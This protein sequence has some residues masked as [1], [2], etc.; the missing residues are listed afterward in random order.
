MTTL[1]SLFDRTRRLYKDS[2]AIVDDEA[3]FTWNEF[4][5][6]LSRAANLLAKMGLEKGD[7]YAILSTNSFRHAEL[8][9]G[10]YWS[11]CI[12]VP[13]N[14]RLAPKEIAA[15]LED[16]GAKFLFIE[17]SF[18]EVLETEEL[19]S[20]KSRHLLLPTPGGPKN[21]E[22]DDLLE[23]CSP[24]KPQIAEDEDLAILIY[25]G[26]TTGRSKGVRLTHRNIIT[27]GMQVALAFQLKS[28]DI[29]LH[30]A[31]MFHSAD[32]LGTGFLMLGTA[33]AYISN[34]TPKSILEMLEKTKTTSIMLPPTLVIGILQEPD[35]ANYDLSNLR[36]LFYG[37]A[38]MDAEWI[39]KTL[40]A[41]PNTEIIQLYGTTEASPILTSLGDLEHR[42]AVE[43]EREELLKSAGRTVLGLDLIIV[44]DDGNEVPRGEHGEVALRGGNLTKGYLNL[45]EVTKKTIRG[46]Y[47]HTGDVGWMDEQGYLFLLDRKNDMII[48]G[49]ENV[50][51][52]EVEAALYKHPN[53]HETAVVGIPDEKYG[54]AVFAAIV[55]KPGTSI[56]EQ[57]IIDHCRQYIGGFKIPRTM[58]FV[59]ALPKSA[60]GKIL[61]TELRKEYGGGK[62]V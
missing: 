12:P 44:D 42:R 36:I 11:G 56:T 35:L 23:G 24:A 19:D 62:P 33:H 43:G 37:S 34:P 45:P 15:I 40:T 8:I 55:P 25:T 58:A 52:S 53:V 31:P 61:K 5:D 60:V 30:V 48:T 54:E 47:F 13:I 17:E 27:N 2:I 28:E 32:L 46:G 38:P 18:K 21:Q 57:E 1:V 39:K 20:F 29:M 41:F 16:S 59:E 6:R 22:Y 51:S 14:Y 4:V 26:G 10:G 9:Y 7:R 49:A 50:Y 3:V